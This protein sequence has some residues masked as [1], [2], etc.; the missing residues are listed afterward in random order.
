M[1]GTMT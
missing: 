1:K